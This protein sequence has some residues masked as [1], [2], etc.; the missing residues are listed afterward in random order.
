MKSSQSIAVDLVNPLRLESIPIHRKDRLPSCAG[1]YFAIA[2]GQILYIG[3]SQNIR[4]RWGNHHRLGDLQSIDGVSL[5]WV[6]FSG[7]SSELHLMEQRFIKAYLPVLNNGPVF[8]PQRVGKKPRRKLGPRSWDSKQTPG[9]GTFIYLGRHEITDLGESHKYLAPIG[10]GAWFPEWIVT[11]MV[12]VDPEDF[13]D[14][15]YWMAQKVRKKQQW[16]RWVEKVRASAELNDIPIEEALNQIA[17][18][19]LKL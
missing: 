18:G 1:V 7:S 5:A 8:Y 16:V 2:H 14:E 12:G 3:K 6:T 11:L 17:A 9:V 19:T 10:R 4:R 15:Q 13:C